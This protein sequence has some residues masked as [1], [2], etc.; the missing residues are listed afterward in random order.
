MT[1]GVLQTFMTVYYSQEKERAK[2]LLEENARAAAERSMKEH[3][4]RLQ[5]HPTVKQ[6]SNKQKETSKGNINLKQKHLVTKV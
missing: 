2:M 5:I 1:A 4:E 6:P 3:K